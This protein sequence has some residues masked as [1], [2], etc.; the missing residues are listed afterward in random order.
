MRKTSLRPTLAALALLAAAPAF[1][2][3]A[4]PPAQPPAAA[5]G[6]GAGPR[7]PERM[8]QH[9]D[10]NAD[11]RVTREE[12]MAWLA[13][14]FAQA[15]TDRDGALSLAEF[16]AAQGPRGPGAGPHG[17]P[18]RAAERRAAVFRALDANSD[19]RVTLEEIRPVAEARFRAAD[20]NGDGVVTREEL[21][22]RHAHRGPG[23]PAR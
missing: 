12:A 11:G 13:G 2:Q 19:G 7:G 14:R 17:D 15:D 18:A 20:A 23:A 9:L 16:Q 10:T 21:P 1:A 8:F 22:Q 3:P 4:Q 5:P 6:S